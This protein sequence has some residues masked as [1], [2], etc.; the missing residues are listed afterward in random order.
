MA[1]AGLDVH[2]D[3]RELQKL[4]ADLKGVEGNLRV[5]LRRGI[6]SAAKPVV[7][8]AKNDAGFSSKIPATVKTKVSFSAKNPSVAIVAGGKG[9]PDAAP[10]NNRGKRGTFRHPVFGHTDRW[11]TQAARPFMQN[12]LDSHAPDVE[13]AILDV[14]DVVMGKA[15]FR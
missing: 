5:E 13:R 12:N 3:A 10:F 2:V 11:V 9:A 15:G 6:V 7:A 4:Y 8:A 1:G 14:I